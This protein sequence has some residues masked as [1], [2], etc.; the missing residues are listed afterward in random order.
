MYPP[1]TERALL[2]ETLLQVGLTTFIKACQDE[3]AKPSDDE[4]EPLIPIPGPVETL[5]GPPHRHDPGLVVANRHNWGEARPGIPYEILVLDS[6]RP[7]GVI[8]LSR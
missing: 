8:P 3:M 4:Q 7:L 5:R 6:S 1:V 2:S